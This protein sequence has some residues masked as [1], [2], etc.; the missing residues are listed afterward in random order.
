MLGEIFN[1]EKIPNSTITA[2]DSIFPNIRSRGLKQNARL[3]EK[4][5]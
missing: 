5:K 3:C 4:S 1:Y 2:F